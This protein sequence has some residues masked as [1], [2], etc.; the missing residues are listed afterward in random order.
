MKSQQLV[1]LRAA[2][3]DVSAMCNID[4]SLDYKYIEARFENEGAEFL[5]VSLPQFAKDLE[6]ALELGVVPN[7]LFEGFSRRGYSKLPVFLGGLMGYIF[8]P[9]SGVLRSVDHSPFFRDDFKRVIYA[10]PDDEQR[11]SRIDYVAL[12]IRSIRQICLLFSKMKKQCSE[13]RTKAAF[14][15]YAQCETEIRM[16]ERVLKKDPTL[17]RSFQRMSTV[18]FGDVLCEMDRMIQND[19][20]RPQHGPGAT[21]EKLIGNKKY[22]QTEWPTRMEDVFPYGEFVRP[23]WVSPESFGLELEPDYVEPEAERPV[24]VI[25]VPKTQK[26]PRI[27]AIEPTCMQYMQQGLMEAIYE[28]FD[29]DSFLNPFISTESQVPNQHLAL[30]G[31][32][33]N[34]LATLDLSEA[35]DRISYLH[36]QLMLDRHTSTRMYVDACRSRKADVPGIGVIDLSKFASMGSALTF[37]FESMVFLALVFLGIESTLNT[38]LTRES[39]K[40]YSG[41]VRV[42]GDDIIVPVEFVAAVIESLE[43]FGYLVNSGKSFWN[44]SFRESCGKEYWYGRD[45]SIVKVRT[46]FPTS[47]A[48]TDEIISTVSLRNQ[49]WKTHCFPHT[50]DLL[51]EWIEDII[52][53]PVVE[54]TSPILGRLSYEKFNP[55]YWD[56]DLQ[57]PLVKGM[58]V[59]AKPR[60]SF[61]DGEAALMK[62]FLK[63]GVLPF[64]DRN[65]LL[66]GGRPVSVALKH[67]KALP[68]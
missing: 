29:R 26:T 62:F 68:Y 4:T 41:K 16:H 2:L 40:G 63:R 60:K 45:V 67:G 57:V 19:E 44:G 25:S 9:S 52:P 3:T 30:E 46:D 14:M 55:Q 35:S 53:F 1:F 15:K 22:L 20:I 51:D 7:Y 11:Y 18:L 33:Q 64:F 66:Y 28:Y 65:H 61:L 27:I 31:S 54:E 23:M 38:P 24:R 10:G 32:Y 8:E 37:P 59:I 17:Q 36:V 12:L 13:S 48:H 56:S 34:N 6:R 5:T 49:L 21:A 47:L 58:L 42:Y 50:V 43:S 39:I